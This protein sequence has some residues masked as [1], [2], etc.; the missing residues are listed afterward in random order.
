M[1]KKFEIPTPII[2]LPEDCTIAFL[3][4]KKYLSPKISK[5]EQQNRQAIGPEYEEPPPSSFL[6]RPKDLARD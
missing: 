1:A 5:E 2:L 4:C 3:K 6:L